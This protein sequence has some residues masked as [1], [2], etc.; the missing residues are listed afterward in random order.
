[1]GPSPRSG[2]ETL[3]NLLLEKT[4]CDLATPWQHF[5]PF[6]TRGHSLMVKLQPSK[7]AMRVRFSLPAYP[8]P[9]KAL[10]QDKTLGGTLFPNCFSFK[11][12]H[13]SGSSISPKRQSHNVNDETLAQFHRCRRR[14]NSAR[15][16]AK[17][18]TF[19][20]VDRVRSGSFDR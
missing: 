5:T 3:G 15:N 7:L 14:S 13:R 20:G 19:G 16:P 12:R 18:S 8:P 2:R 17:R 1:M 11:I 4:A 10:T 9:C 6:A